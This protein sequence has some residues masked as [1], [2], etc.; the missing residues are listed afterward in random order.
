MTEKLF[1]KTIYKVFTI[2]VKMTI[3][4]LWKV[5]GALQRLDGIDLKAKVP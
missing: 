2:S 4:N 3:M 1:M 5:G